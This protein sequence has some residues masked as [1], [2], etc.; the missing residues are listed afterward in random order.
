MGSAQNPATELASEAESWLTLVARNS[1]YVAG[2]TLGEVRLRLVDLGLH[3]DRALP[4]VNAAVD[5]TGDVDL[6]LPPLT[7]EETEDSS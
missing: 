7:A 6:E 4:P 5:G 1:Q 3:G 2:A